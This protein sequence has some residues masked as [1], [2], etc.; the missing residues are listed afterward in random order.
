ME[1][2]N[3]RKISEAFQNF[4][5]WENDEDLLNFGS[6]NLLDDQLGLESP[7]IPDLSLNTNKLE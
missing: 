3:T 1:S 4:D 6:I 2:C 5:E 7:D